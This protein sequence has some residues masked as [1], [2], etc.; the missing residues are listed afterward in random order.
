M[1]YVYVAGAICP[2]NGH[3]VVEYW[4][5]LNKGFHLSIELALAGYYPFCPHL[6]Y[7]YYTT[8]IGMGIEPSEE[9]FYNLSIAHLEN[10]DAVVLCDGWEG[11]KGT[12]KE[13]ERADELGIPVFP[14]LRA[15][16]EAEERD[17]V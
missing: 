7:N 5:N 4:K 15:F 6:D 11:S 1:R 16:L 17:D 8:L 9:F 13:V 2:T 10:Q 14:S 12:L 3:P